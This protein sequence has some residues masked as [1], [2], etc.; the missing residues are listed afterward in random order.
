MYSHI[1]SNLCQGIA[2][3][4]QQIAIH[5]CLQSTALIHSVPSAMRHAVLGGTSGSSPKN[6]LYM[7]TVM[8]KLMISCSGNSGVS[9]SAVRVSGHNDFWRLLISLYLWESAD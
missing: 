5:T 8:R 3:I 2:D 9:K 7:A 6:I 1:I 4:I